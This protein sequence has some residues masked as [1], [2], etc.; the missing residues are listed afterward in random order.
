VDKNVPDVEHVTVKME[1]VNVMLVMKEKTAQDHP[2]LMAAPTMEA[3]L[4][5]NVYVTSHTLEL[6]VLPASVLV[7]MIL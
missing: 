1:T 2:V 5:E 4:M 7:E 3:V 6:T